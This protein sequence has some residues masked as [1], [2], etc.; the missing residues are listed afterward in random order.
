MMTCDTCAVDHVVRNPGGFHLCILKAIKNWTWEE[1][2][3]NLP[4]PI[5]AMTTS[6]ILIGI[7]RLLYIQWVVC[8]KCVQGGHMS[9]C[10]QDRT[11]LGCN[12]GPMYMSFR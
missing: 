3:L 2:R 6:L 10:G 11:D 12:C 8:T 5:V 1:A 7:I 9:L 4:L